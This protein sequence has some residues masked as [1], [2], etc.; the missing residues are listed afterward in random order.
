MAI[1]VE[2]IRGPQV[3][4]T[5]QIE[6]CYYNDLVARLARF[7]GESVEA[8]AKQFMEENLSLLRER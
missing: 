7:G 4:L 5:I 2:A 1:S 3:A 8:I 6:E